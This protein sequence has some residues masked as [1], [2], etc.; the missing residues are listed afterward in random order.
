MSNIIQI[1]EYHPPNT[2]A[3]FDD[4]ER[5]V[6]DNLAKLEP[7][8]S[9]SFGRDHL[10]GH[11]TI[12]RQQLVITR[13]PDPLGG[14]SLKD[15]GDNPS[16][17]GTQ[18]WRLQADKDGQYSY[19]WGPV[20]FIVFFAAICIRVGKVKNEDG[21]ILSLKV[22]EAQKD[23]FPYTEASGSLAQQGNPLL[24]PWASKLK[25]LI[26]QSKPHEISA[27]NLKEGKNIALGVAKTIDEGYRTKVGKGYVGS[28]I[29]AEN[30][31]YFCR[32]HIRAGKQKESCLV[33]V[34][35]N[36]TTSVITRKNII[37][38]INNGTSRV[39]E[40]GETLQFSGNPGGSAT[41]F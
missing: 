17:N 5:S 10:G 14:Y 34:A 2:S 38:E 39:I 31:G 25:Q 40:P 12:S 37:D 30:Q 20:N 13:R 23:A 15:G 11:Q 16:G 21:Y 4:I 8:Q 6:A 28:P 33:F 29:M 9:V 35:V 7:G 26:E 1:P 27:G 36:G 22:P 3:G 41:W 18:I 24:S 32:F 19:G